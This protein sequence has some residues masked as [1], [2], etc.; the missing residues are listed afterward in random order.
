MLVDV[1]PAAVLLANQHPVRKAN[2]VEEHLAQTEDA[3][4]D[5][6][7]PVDRDARKVVG[8]EKQRD[9]GMLRD[10]RVRPG[11]QHDHVVGCVRSRR[12]EL[13][14]GDHV[15]VAVTTGFRLERGRVRSR[16]PALGQAERQLDL[17]TLTD[18]SK[19][20]GRIASL[21][22][23]ARINRSPADQREAF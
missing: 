19:D 6:V 3:A 7:E 20:F 4:T 1:F 14:T 5:H 15:V 17:A 21:A 10:V 8:N 11:G 2:I 9:T 23:S 12:V 22:K 18:A 13:L 16:V